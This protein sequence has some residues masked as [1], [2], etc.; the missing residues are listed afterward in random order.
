VI[1]DEL[2]GSAR[3]LERDAN[4]TDMHLDGLGFGAAIEAVLIEVFE[5]ALVGEHLAAPLIQQLEKP[6][7]NA[8]EADALLG[9]EGAVTDEAQLAAGFPELVAEGTMDGRRGG[10]LVLQ[11]MSQTTA[12]AKRTMKTTEAV[13]IGPCSRS[14]GRRDRRRGTAS[15]LVSRKQGT[16]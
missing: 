16:G 8:V 15:L 12:T 11:I 13:V 10:H 2:E 3:A 4:A 7:L 1:T 6:H 9:E 14:R 5:D